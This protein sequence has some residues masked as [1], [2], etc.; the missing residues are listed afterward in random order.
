MDDSIDP[1]STNYY[2]KFKLGD[3]RDDQSVTY[4]MHIGKATSS[5]EGLYGLS[6]VSG[7]HFPDVE[8]WAKFLR[9]NT[10]SITVVDEY[11][12]EQDTE[13]F[14]AEF[15]EDNAPTSARQIKWMQDHRGDP[16]YDFNDRL[17]IWDE[18][19]ADAWRN[20]HWIDEASGK[21]FYTGEFS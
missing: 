6:T 3:P 18:P 19:Q 1:M 8:S 15:L 7:K 2:A 20:R 5:G 21:L 10:D 14:I 16:R 11:G 13:K 4:S 12:A 17:K 9:H